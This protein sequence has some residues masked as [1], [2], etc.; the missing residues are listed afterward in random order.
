MD[1][2]I[3][4]SFSEFINQ[5]DTLSIFS[6]ITLFRGQPQK[7][8]LLPRVARKNPKYN[9]TND[10]INQLE[11]LRL[12]GASFI[13][14][15]NDWDLL[16]R[17]QHFGLKTRLLDWTSNPLVALWFACVDKKPGDVYVYALAAGTL[18]VKDIY[19]K[20]PFEQSETRIIQPK[21]NN[22]RIIAQNGWFTAHRY[23]AKAKKFVALEANPKIG[24]HLSEFCIPKSKRCEILDALDRHGINHKTVFP[25]FYGV[26]KY[27]NWKCKVM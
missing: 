8:N 1:T 21:L 5:T 24:S 25:D 4:N 17:S 11:Q 14:D 13:P 19:N 2:E 3:I 12:I 9:T 26:C 10:E 7:G 18:L 22:A 16:I 6:S 23:S 27:L 15:E 20:D